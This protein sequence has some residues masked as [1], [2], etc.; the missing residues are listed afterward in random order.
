MILCLLLFFPPVIATG[1]LLRKTDKKLM[2]LSI[3]ILYGMF[4]LFV[5]LA[6]LLTVSLLF[7]GGFILSP[8]LISVSYSY[9]YLLLSSCFSIIFGHV[10]CCAIK[11]Y[12]LLVENVSFSIHICRRERK[13]NTRWILPVFG[14]VLF[15]FEF[16]YIVMAV[17]KRSFSSYLFHISDTMPLNSDAYFSFWAILKYILFPAV[18]ISVC[19]A[20]FYLLLFRY[21][22]YGFSATYKVKKTDSEISLFLPSFISKL[23]K[24]SFLVVCFATTSVSI[25]IGCLF[26]WHRHKPTLPEWVMQSNRLVAHAGGGIGNRT[27]INSIDA[28]EFNYAQGHRVFEVDFSLTHDNVLVA[29]H[30]WNQQGYS[31]ISPNIQTFKSNLIFEQYKP[32][33]FEEIAVFL[34]E[35]TDAYIITDKIVSG[36]ETAFRN[37]IDTCNALDPSLLSRIIVQ[38]YD[39]DGYYEVTEKYSGLGVLYTLY[40]TTDTMDEVVSFVEKTGIK[41]IVMPDIWGTP[42]YFKKFQ[43][44]GAVVFSHTV[45]DVSTFNA[46]R[47]AGVYGIYTDF[48][49]PG[50]IAQ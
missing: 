32:T 31:G 25:Y 22:K 24:I 21:N 19:A 38:I 33:T 37:I 5:N 11:L 9:K 34:Q 4:T 12:A 18:L 6:N 14:A 47:S 13:L 35:H 48:L 16:R 50:E 41:V 30:D 15:F 42:E 10:T 7:E 46:L 1:I 2:L 40:S 49:K 44:R 43:Q 28:I 29:I 27:Y 20:I 17:G 8:K 3:L 39:Q 23:K 36:N 45:N 26:Y